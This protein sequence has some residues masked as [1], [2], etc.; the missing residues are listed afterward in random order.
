MIVQ[1]IRKLLNT[2]ELL[3]VQYII[4]SNKA[5]YDIWFYEVK[6]YND[7]DFNEKLDALL[8]K[9]HL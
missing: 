5:P 2:I 3:T 9:I 1:R 6:Y 4:M 7:I 8:D